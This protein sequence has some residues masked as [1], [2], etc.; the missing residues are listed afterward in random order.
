MEC[1][2]RIRPIEFDSIVVSGVSG[3]LVGAQ[4][5]EILDKNIVVVRKKN[6]KRYSPFHIEGAYPGDYI[7]VDD[8][9]CSGSTVRRIFSEIKTE[10]PRSKA[11][12]MY[13]YIPEDC[14]YSSC[15]EIFKREFGVEYLN[16]CK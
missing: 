1:C 9:V 14:G 3:L 8:L 6:E 12:G 15:P 7:V 16:P 10:Y 5:A 13:C 4:I 2:S 11:V